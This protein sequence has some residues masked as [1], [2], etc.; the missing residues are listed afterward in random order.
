MENK[1]K[2]IIDETGVKVTFISEKTGVS[3][4]TLYDIMNKKTIPNVCIAKKICS[5]LGKE[6]EEVFIFD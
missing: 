3:R 2:E 4:Q 6:L 5:A 1:L